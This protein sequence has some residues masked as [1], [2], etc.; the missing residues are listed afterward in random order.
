MNTLSSE[1]ITK[2]FG[3]VHSN[4]HPHETTVAYV[5]ILLLPYANT[6]EQ[7]NSLQ[8][9][10]QWIPLA[11]PGKL[12]KH[13]HQEF[14]KAVDITYYGKNIGSQ[15][16]DPEI[17]DNDPE[18]LSISKYTVIEYLIAEIA[19]LAGNI[20]KNADDGYIILPWDVLRGIGEDYELSKVFGIVP[21]MNKLPVSVTVGDNQ[22]TEEMSMDMTMGILLFSYHTVGNVDFNVHMFGIRLRPGLDQFN[23]NHTPRTFRYYWHGGY[24]HENFTVVVRR[25]TYTFDT[26]EFMQEFVTGAQWAG[27][28][29]HKYWSDLKFH[30]MGPDGQRVATNV[31]F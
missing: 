10:S 19:E 31:T 20:A 9:I 8:V 21:G 6:L 23:D 11:L 29:H 2:I 16:L 22:I 26:P 4:L 24:D 3:Q 27:V 13:A 7:G 25:I 5:Q 30:S 28:D 18:L 1:T 15:I 12:G 14:I 17:P